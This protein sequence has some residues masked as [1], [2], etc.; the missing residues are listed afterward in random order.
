QA[1]EQGRRAA[2]A[3]QRVAQAVAQRDRGA[4]ALQGACSLGGGVVLGLRRQLVVEVVVSADEGL[5]LLAD[6]VLVGGGGDL[7]RSGGL[8]LQL[9]RQAIDHIAQRVGGRADRRAVDQ[10]RG[11]G[12]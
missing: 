7:H 4:V 10:C 12:G 3:A 2:G 9:Q 11:V 5:D 6:R 8:A 1:R